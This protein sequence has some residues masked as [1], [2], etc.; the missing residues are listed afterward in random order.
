MSPWPGKY[1]IGLTGNIAAGKSVVRRM[2]EH[3]GAYGIDADALAHMAIAKGAPGYKPVVAYFGQ[4]VLDENGQINRSK[5]GKLVFSDP[6]ALAKL[7]SIIHPLVRQAIDMFVRRTKKTVIVIEAIKLLEGD[8][9]KSCDSIWVAHAS[10]TNR[11]KRLVE[12][13]RMGE[14]EAQQRIDAQGSPGDKLAAA[15]VIIRNDTSFENTWGQVSAAWAR[16]FPSDEDTEPFAVVAGDATLS[17]QRA[18]P[19]QAEQIAQLVGHLSSGKRRLTRS[20]VMAEFGEKA[21]LLLFA[22]SRPVG[23][24]GWQVE[25]LVTRTTDFYLEAGIPLAEAAEKL[26][27]QVEETSRELQSEAA[28]FFMPEAYAGQAAVWSKLGYEK[29]SI[30]ALTVRAWQEAARESHVDGSEL[31]FKQLRVDR[32][33]RPI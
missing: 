15:D 19:S 11:L 18:R 22:G 17:V 23:L 5:L 1:V 30:E 27:A 25:N 31:Y 8:L 2:L 32:V 21:F 28:L 13:R 20:D 7:E 24:L 12:K 33:L 10:A 4:Y 3:L 6:A 16:I 26:V 29:R 9:H 14:A